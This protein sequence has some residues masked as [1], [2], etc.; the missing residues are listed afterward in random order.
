MLWEGVG[1]LVHHAGKVW[2]LGVN[3]VTF[4][5]GRPELI[6]SFVHGKVSS[7][8]SLLPRA[9]LA[10]VLAQARSVLLLLRLNSEVKAADVSC[11]LTRVVQVTKLGRFQPGDLGVVHLM[12]LLKLLTFWCSV[13]W[14]L[15]LDGRTFR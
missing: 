4:D 6:L 11:V 14:V 3:V 10:P 8:L 12:L 15:V 2:E 1:V 5:Y 7:E 9:V 13:T